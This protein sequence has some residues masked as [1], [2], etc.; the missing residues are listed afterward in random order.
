LC[1]NPF[2]WAGAFCDAS[3][4][5]RSITKGPEMPCISEGEAQLLGHVQRK[6]LLVAVMAAAASA[7]LGSPSFRGYTGLVVIPTAHVLDVG[8]YDFGVMTE[9]TAVSHVNDVFATYSPREKL[10]VGINDFQ[11]GGSNGRKPLL[12]AKYL[13]APETDEA[14][15]VAVGVIDFTNEIQISPYAVASKTI[16]RRASIFHSGVISLRGHAG[17]GFGSFNAL[18]VGLS[19]YAGNRI[20]LSLEWDSKNVNLGFRL[21]PIKGLRL[22]SALFDSGNT[23]HIGLGA[24]Y[25]RTF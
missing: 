5:T 10:E 8:E 1:Y 15:A 2:S 18:F 25:T 14:C 3:G 21:T 24:S 22:Y 12:N 9:D 13:V 16:V 20:M 19:A 23:D 17:F 11:P 4:L 6:I 7:A